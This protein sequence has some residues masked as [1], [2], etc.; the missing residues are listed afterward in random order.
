MWATGLSTPYITLCTVA[1]VFLKEKQANVSLSGHN[2]KKAADLEPECTNEAHIPDKEIFAYAT[3]P[4]KCLPG[5]RRGH[6]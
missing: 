6:M 3:G 1:V 5:V 4:Q 2:P